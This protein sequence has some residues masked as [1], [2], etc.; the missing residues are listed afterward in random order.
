MVDETQ[1]ATPREYTDA[2]IRT[3]KLFLGGLR[4]LQ[5]N[6]KQYER[7]CNKKIINFRNGAKQVAKGNAV[8]ADPLN[9]Y[10]PGELI[11]NFDSQPSFSKFNFKLQFILET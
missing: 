1:M 2:F 7:P 3:K 10:V 6:S 8:L 11:V 5:S 4:G 9:P